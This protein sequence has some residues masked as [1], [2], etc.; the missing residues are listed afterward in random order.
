MKKILLLLGVSAFVLSSCELNE[1]PLA[2]AT[3]ND[4]FGTASGLK[5]YSYSFYNNITSGTSAYQGDAMSD[6][7]AVNS[8]NDFIR[9]GGYSAET[10][11]G[12]SWSALRNINHFI[13]NCNNPNV[14]ETVRNNYIGIARFFRAWF[15][16]DKVSTF[17]DVPWIDRP[18]GV[19]EEEVLYGT[20]DS[21]AL[22]MEKVLEDLDFAYNHISATAS[23]GTTITKWTA[24][25]LKTRVALFEASFRKYHPELGLSSTAN[26]LYQEVVDAGLE[27]MTKGPH[28]LNT[29]QGIDASQR[30]LF[31]SDAPVT[32]EVM[33]AVAFNKELALMNSANW[34]WTSATYGPRFS[35][36]RPFINT[37]LNIDGTPYTNRPNY[38]TEEFYDETQGRD[39]RLSQLIRT[40]GYKRAGVVTAP[41]FA[42]YTY[43]GYQPIKYTL[44][45]PYYDNGAY[46]TNAVPLMRYAEVL[47]NFAEAKAELGQLTAEDWT[48]TIGALRARSGVTGGINVLPTQVD[49]YLQQTFF[50][51]IN[52]PI[53]LEVRRERQVELALEGFRFDDLK[54]WNRGELLANLEW[55]GIYVPALDQLIDL[56]RN[57]TMDVVFFDGSMS[58]PSIAV[59][60]GVAKV[61]V[62]GKVTNFQTLTPN[63]HLEWFKAQTRTWY[64]DGRQN[65]YP[66]PAS[67]IT[68]NQNLTQNKGW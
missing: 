48:K 57:G 54:R 53:L 66:I 8:I 52:D 2:T 36:V 49:T 22:V 42:S 12:W 10:S 11:T 25:G 3:E 17:G 58:E 46:N 60:A 31:I 33:L 13:V 27:L 19:N 51:G 9:E 61:A 67:A 30:Q 62:G 4:I 38:E 65:L 18:L 43:T 24:L 28:S 26:E 6:Y 56:D 40:P 7:G 21:R 15:Y 39:K 37:I 55:T 1:E 35:L 14:S 68:K 50:P 63:N 41:N 45:D 47:L 32:N 44:D 5:T 34:W 59:P 64:S 29:A 23:D 20:R 16:L